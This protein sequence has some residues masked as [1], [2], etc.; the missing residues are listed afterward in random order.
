MVEISISGE[1]L[2]V[3]VKGLDKLWSFKSRLEIPVAHIRAVRADT[4]IARGWWN[5]RAS[6]CNQVAQRRDSWPRFSRYFSRSAARS[7]LWFDATPQRAFFH[8]P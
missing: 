2:H 7:A 5:R 3:E 6:R 8:L 4:S 1:T